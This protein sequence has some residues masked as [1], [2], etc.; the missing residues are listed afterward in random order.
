MS[1]SP[2]NGRPLF[3]P[4]SDHNGKFTGWQ[5]ILHSMCRY[6]VQ[7]MPDALRLS[8]LR[9]RFSLMAGSLLN[10]QSGR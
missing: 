3:N 5:V 7:Q 2:C 1:P 6:T 4:V 9:G 10:R 8:V